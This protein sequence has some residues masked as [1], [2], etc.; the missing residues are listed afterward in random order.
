MPLALTFQAAE[1]LSLLYLLFI[2]WRWS[3]R[4]IGRSRVYLL[5][6]VLVLLWSIVWA[7]IFPI[8]VRGVLDGREMVEAFPD[9]T[10]VMGVLAAGIPTMIW[11]LLKQPIK[12][13]EHK[14]SPNSSI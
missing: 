5:A 8:A 7:I 12:K 9:G 2:V 10:I 13:A 3:K 11:A 1:I 14:Q 4:P 6:W